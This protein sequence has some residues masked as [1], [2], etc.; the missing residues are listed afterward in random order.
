MIYRG[1]G[2]ELIKPK[3]A[4]LGGFA[5]ARITA[6]FSDVV[7]GEAADGKGVR[8]S[9]PIH[10]FARFDV[11]EHHECTGLLQTHCFLG[12]DILITGRNMR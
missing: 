12:S 5:V 2:L 4:F 8:K 11:G 7:L 3:A 9:R 1:D 6:G 10:G